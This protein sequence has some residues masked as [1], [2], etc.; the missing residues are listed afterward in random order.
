LPKKENPSRPNCHINYRQELIQSNYIKSQNFYPR[1]GEFDIMENI[2]K[3]KEREKV[4]EDLIYTTN[5]KNQDY[6]VQIEINKIYV[7]ILYSIIFILLFV[8]FIIIVIKFYCKCKK[9]IN[10][11][12]IIY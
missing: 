12:I 8:I 2:E 9:V 5:S 1:E 7:K 10:N 4:L 6:K 11:K 3:L